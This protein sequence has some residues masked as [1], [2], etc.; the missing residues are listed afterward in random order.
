MRAS[1]AIKASG[2]VGG[3]SFKQKKVDRALRGMGLEHARV[4]RL[5]LLVKELPRRHPEMA[6]LCHACVT[7]DK[8]Q[9]V[10]SRIER[11]ADV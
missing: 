2:V 9:G 10:V 11:S 7:W 3:L 6:C 1:S 8:L 4:K 5:L